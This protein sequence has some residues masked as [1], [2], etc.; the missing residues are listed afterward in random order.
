MKINKRLTRSEFRD[1]FGTSDQCLQYLSDQKW[2]GGYRCQKCG[3]G[4]HV[5]GKKMHGR[6]CTRCGY[7]ESPTSH[8]VFHK[9]KSGIDKAFEMTF[10]IV[11]L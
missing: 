7:D 2:S 6:G 4:K 10:D 8:T 11:V 3:H 1:H 5:E 9:V